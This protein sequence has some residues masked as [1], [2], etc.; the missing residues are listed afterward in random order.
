MSGE[1]EDGI[2]AP[3]VFWP[4]RCDSHWLVKKT[5]QLLSS[6]FTDGKALVFSRSFSPS[7]HPKHDVCDLDSQENI[8]PTFPNK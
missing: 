6:G 3:V 4:R 5:T 8:L 7:S 1:I 2:L